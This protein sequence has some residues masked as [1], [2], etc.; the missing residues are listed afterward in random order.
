MATFFEDRLETGSGEKVKI[1]V[2]SA[3]GG[4]DRTIYK[5]GVDSGYYLGDNND[6]VY[7]NGQHV[8]DSLMDLVR[9]RFWRGKFKGAFAPSFLLQFYFILYNKFIK[10]NWW[11]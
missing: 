10:N 3:R 2:P 5:N 8:A 11:K 6:H 1:R 7:R 9:T 4:T